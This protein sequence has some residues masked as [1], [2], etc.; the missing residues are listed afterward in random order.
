V[1]DVFDANGQ[2]VKQLV[3]MGGALNAPWGIAL[4]PADFGSLSNALLIGNFGDGRI[5]AY[6][7]ATG[8]TLGAVTDATGAAFARPGLWGIA[9]GND[10]ASLDQPHNALFFTAGTHDETNGLYG[11]VDPK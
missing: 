7:P 9:F 1:V 2:F 10:A 3:P 11:R 4:A 6:D 5:N 8:R